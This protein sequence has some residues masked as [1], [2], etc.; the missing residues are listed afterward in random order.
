MQRKHRADDEDGARFST[1]V[2][3]ETL[4][5]INRLRG[6]LEVTRVIRADDDLR[7]LLGAVAD[8]IAESLGFGTVAINLYRRAWD[9]FVV[10]VVRGNERARTTLLGS[11][12]SREEW[13]PIVDDRFLRRGTYFLPHASIDWDDTSPSYVPDLPISD[14][15]EAWHPEDALFV[16]I[17]D[18]DGSV[19]GIVSVDEPA[20]GRRP[21][22]E[23]L[24]VLVA[25]AEHAAL[26]VQGAQ[27]ATRA[28]RHRR[29]LE[30]LLAVSSRLAE[31]SSI[32]VILQAVCVAVR[33]ALAFTNVSI[34]LVEP[35]TGRLQTRAV[36]GWAPDDPAL[37]TV[38]T[39]A[40]LE[41]LLTTDWEVEGC[42]LL[43][44]DEAER[45]VGT[46]EIAYTS[47]SNGRGPW[48]WQNHWL[49]VPLHD[50]QG[51]V[52][53]VIWAD[54]PADRLLPTKERLQALRVFANHATAAILSAEQ[55]QELRFLADHDPL[56][57]LLN[58]RAFIRRLD[59]EVART[60]RYTRG[61]SLVVCDLDGFKAL[62]DRYGHPA[63]D[64]ALCT[65]GAILV[66][67]LRRPDD[68]FRIGGD[69]FALLL[70]EASEADAHEVVARVTEAF[71]ASGDER[72]GGVR[73]SFGV[74]SC[75]R[76][77]A[78]AQGL[79]RRADEALYRAK[80]TGGGVAFAAA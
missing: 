41:P 60:Q 48:A 46:S 50:R 7:V 74:A 56:T 23:E 76:D 47:R 80:R 77:A 31:T 72:L 32:D 68:A 16:L 79:F 65:L 59:A 69:E 33:D 17:R 64:D 34:E 58:R 61:F 63:G 24:D 15:P 28:Q 66:A 42:Q 71:A 45:R 30:Q 62:N 35:R 55:F 3:D 36:V 8:T 37:S 49:F 2:A 26:A 22:D 53:G 14:D 6:L 9:D 40:D 27:E 44:A 54:E 73:P 5:T 25:V 70:A 11:S 4:S 52:I 1:A 57:R 18:A 13:A 75:P 10:A 67:S 20:S 21:T 29:A 38:V 78:D 51:A 12:R 39:L 43:P 19:L